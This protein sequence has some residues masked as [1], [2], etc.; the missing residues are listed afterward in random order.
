M[1]FKYRKLN[2]FL[3]FASFF[4]I[5]RRKIFLSFQKG[6]SLVLILISMELGI[7]QIIPLMYS[8]SPLMYNYRGAQPLSY[9]FDIP[10][11]FSIYTHPAKV[12]ISVEMPIILI[13]LV[14]FVSNGFKFYWIVFCIFQIMSLSPQFLLPVRNEAKF[15]SFR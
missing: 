14:L 2:I 11:Q 10:R 4:N 6:Y 13:V 5:I 15:P 7:G 3:K 9:S 12:W 8:Y 1:R